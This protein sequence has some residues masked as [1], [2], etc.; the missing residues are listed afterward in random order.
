MNSGRVYVEKVYH[1]PEGS[2][3]SKGRAI[4]NILELRK[5]KRSLR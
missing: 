1:I 2:R 3:T 5:V 4:A